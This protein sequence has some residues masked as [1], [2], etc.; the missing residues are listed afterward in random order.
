MFQSKITADKKRVIFITGHHIGSKRR[1]NFHWLADAFWRADYEVIFFT[2]WISWISRLVGDPRFQYFRKE[3]VRRLVWVND[4]LGS[5]VWLTPWHPFNLPLKS[6]NQLT[7]TLFRSYP[8]FPLGEITPIIEQ[9]NLF[10]FE[11]TPGL[12]LFPVF[13]K[14]NDKAQ[15]IYRVSDPLA[16]VNIH[17]IVE[18]AEK[19]WSPHFD[20]ISTTSEYSFRQFANLPHCRLHYHGL[21]KAVFSVNTQSPFP[22]DSINAIFVGNSH[23][24]VDFINSATGLFPQWHFHIIGPFKNLPQR[25]NI[26][27]YGEIPFQQTIPFIQHANIGLQT[28]SYCKGAE[29]L[30][31]TLKVLQYTYCQLPIVAPEFLRTRRTHCFYYTPGD[32]ASI[33]QAL[34]HA[35][36][37]DRNSIDREGIQTWD[38]LQQRMIS[39]LDIISGAQGSSHRMIL[40]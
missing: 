24:D 36:L 18:E 29:H 14:I 39:D 31:D 5:Y 28:R 15:T 9:S 26:H 8:C 19:R 10:I 21:E 22:P 40:P 6:L 16:L 2:C 33:Q 1:A 38:E 11:S 3:S 7:G 30:T 4:H 13:K 12:M 17:P 25:E 34:H 20:L 35:L 37:F 32:T 23:L 27:A